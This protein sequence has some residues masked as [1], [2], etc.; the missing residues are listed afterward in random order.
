MKAHRLFGLILLLSLIFIGR[1]YA[2]G[3]YQHTDDRKKSLVWNNDPKPGDTATWSG[4]RDAEGYA[5]GP[6]TLTWSRLDRGFSTGSN[7]TI[8]RKRTPI[9]SYSGMMVRGKL[10]GGVSTVDRGKTYHATFVDGQK[11]GHWVAG[12][13]IAKAE[14]AE[15]A[16]AAEKEDRAEP[17]R[18]TSTAKEAATTG[19]ITT[20][21][22][23]ANVPEE[24]TSD[25]PAAGPAEEQAEVSAQKPE[26]KQE[27]PQT[28]TVSPPVIAQASAEEPDQSATPR[29]PVTRKAA[30]APGA[31]RA[32]EK[33]THAVS[34][35]T[36]G[37][38]IKQ[39]TRAKSAEEKTDKPVKTAKAA[40]SQSPETEIKLSEDVPAEGPAAPA[41]EQ[42]APPPALHSQSSP[43]EPVAK[44]KPVDDS[45]RTLTG[46]PTSLHPKAPP[47]ETNPPAKITTD[48][49]AAASPPQ[50][51]A[52]K[53]TAVQAM[54][55]ADIE[56]RT[57]G[58]DL[59]EYQLPKAEYNAAN[60]TWS[61]GYAGRDS[62][63]SAKKLSVIVQ[64]KSGKA[65]VKK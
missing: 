31:V 26:I 12:P 37:E 7:V 14:S 20:E 53:L 21:K 16:A 44:E 54:D 56:A 29:E 23:P 39:A 36:E 62:D 2:S 43:T 61:V 3:T 42:I 32:I 57:R 1:S 11:T 17:A 5:T 64:D 58:F 50:Q 6:G 13:L 63:S 4:A 51:S 33:P 18:S 47:P 8:T 41:K 22:K 24:S 35:K 48:S 65:E 10:D 19:K 59:G 46:P 9:S 25:I 52:P 27:K 28:P 49:S 60:D 15:P 55:I 40:P 38:P 34:K 45:I 30:L